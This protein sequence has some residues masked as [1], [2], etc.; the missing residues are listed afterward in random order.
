[1]PRIGANNQFQQSTATT[2]QV[3]PEAV[4][5][6]ALALLAT[7]GRLVVAVKVPY[8]LLEVQAEIVG[9]LVDLS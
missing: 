1:M 2:A 3:L 7:Q 6:D 5:F 9:L 8:D 4:P